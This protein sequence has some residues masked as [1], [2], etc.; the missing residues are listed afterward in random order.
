MLS[1][2]LDKTP[3]AWRYSPQFFAL[4]SRLNSNFIRMVERY[5]S[6]TGAAR[7]PHSWRQGQNT[8]LINHLGSKALN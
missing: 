7:L 3:A 4:L 8:V 2:L 6:A 5:E 1:H